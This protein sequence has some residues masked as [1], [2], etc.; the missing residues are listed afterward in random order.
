MH[1]GFLRFYEKHNKNE[2]ERKSESKQ[3]SISFRNIIPALN[4]LNVTRKRFYQTQCNV[5]TPY[6]QLKIVKNVV[7]L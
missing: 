5:I 4:K 6:K 3:E 7:F 1:L 2:N